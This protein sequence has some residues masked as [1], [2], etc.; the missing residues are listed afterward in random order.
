MGAAIG[1]LVVVLII[2]GLAWSQIST[3]KSRQYPRNTPQSGSSSSKDGDPSGP[4]P[5]DSV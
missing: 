4:P 5:T 2:G 1:V 3:L